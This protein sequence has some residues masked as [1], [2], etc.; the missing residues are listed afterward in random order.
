MSTRLS[1]L[2]QN[3]RTLTQIFLTHQPSTFGCRFLGWTWLVY[4]HFDE[5]KP[6]F[7]STGRSFCR[8]LKWFNFI[9]ISSNSGHFELFPKTIGQQMKR[10]QRKEPR[11][12]LVAGD[13][14][15]Q[16]RSADTLLE[17]RTFCYV[18][19]RNFFNV[20]S[21]VLGNSSIWPELDDLSIK[22]N[23]FKIRQ[24]LRP[25]DTKDGLI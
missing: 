18:A 22:L 2:C 4:R 14:N 7:V 19:G 9:E 12:T 10:G 5:I 21:I 16:Q 1:G 13:S 11:A 23:H 20:R 8:I 15:P 17:I 6:S 25:V 3:F 24:K